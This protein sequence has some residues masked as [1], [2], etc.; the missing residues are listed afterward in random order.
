[1][2]GKEFVQMGI[3]LTI[4][5]S[6]SKDRKS[7]SNALMT[8]KKKVVIFQVNPVIPTTLMLTISPKS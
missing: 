3:L 5:F 2:D 1:M 8:S 6:S 4:F 7:T